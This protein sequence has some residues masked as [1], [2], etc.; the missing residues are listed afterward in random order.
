MCPG[1]YDE[2]WWEEEV[3]RPPTIRNKEP[4]RRILDD[5]VNKRTNST[6]KMWVSTILCSKHPCHPSIYV[7]IYMKKEAMGAKDEDET[8]RVHTGGGK[9]RQAIS[10][11]LPMDRWMGVGPSFIALERGGV[12]LIMVA[13]QVSSHLMVAFFACFACLSCQSPSRKK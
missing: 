3:C 2:K 8:R 7:P 12:G 1:A 10:W 4:T 5:A 11:K 6:D 13:L 9:R